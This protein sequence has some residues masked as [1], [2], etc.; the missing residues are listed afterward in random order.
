MPQ[1]QAAH[2]PLSRPVRLPRGLGSKPV[3][4]LCQCQRWWRASF[5]GVAAVAAERE[6]GTGSAVRFGEGFSWEGSIVWLLKARL[7]CFSKSI[8]L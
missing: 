2:R 1:W 3:L 4:A 5:V 7:N 6:G 8:S